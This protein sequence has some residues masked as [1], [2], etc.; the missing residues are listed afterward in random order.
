MAL[1]DQIFTFSMLSFFWFLVLQKMLKIAFPKNA[2]FAIFFFK[3]HHFHLFLLFFTFFVSK[4]PFF[5]QNF[6]FVDEVIGDTLE[7]RGMITGVRLVQE[8]KFWKN[9]KKM[10]KKMEK[11]YENEQK[12]MKF[13]LFLKKIKKLKFFCFS[14]KSYFLILWIFKI[15]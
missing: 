4:F 10:E 8:N 2:D 13:K 1:F 15:S 5:Y 9:E 11:K 7:P 12:L 6:N 3:F 14:Q